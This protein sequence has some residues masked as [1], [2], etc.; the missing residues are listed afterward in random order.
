[1]KWNIGLLYIYLTKHFLICKSFLPIHNQIRLLS[2]NDIYKYGSKA[3]KLYKSD[4]NYTN[5][6]EDHHCIP[7]QWRDHE[8]LE[9]LKFDINGSNNLYIMPNKKGKNNL[10]LHPNTIIHQGGHAKYNIFVKYHLDEI[11]KL[12]YENSKYEFWLLLHYLKKNMN[13]N[14]DNIPWK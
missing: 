4:K 1:M 5:L 12:P 6:V 3:R 2:N 8:L 10:N 11:N 13:T 7:K 9:K 14:D